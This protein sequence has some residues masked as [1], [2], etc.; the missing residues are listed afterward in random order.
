[1]IA[2]VQLFK[3]RWHLTII[4]SKLDRKKQTS[5]SLHKRNSYNL[6]IP[7]IGF[8]D[9]PFHL[10]DQTE[11]FSIILLKK[12][13]NYNYKKFVNFIIRILSKSTYEGINT[14]EA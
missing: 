10:K 2:T 1:M 4:Y 11:L 8:T 13:C 12:S 7:P 3:A 5:V 14:V 9:S 6:Y